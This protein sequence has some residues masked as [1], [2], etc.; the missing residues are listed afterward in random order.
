MTVFIDTCVYLDYLRSAELHVLDV[1][2]E[3]I[4]ARKIKL[5]F[6]DVTR[7]EIW[8]GIPIDYGRYTKNKFKLSMPSVP[9][10]V[11]KGKK[12]EKAKKLLEDYSSAIEEVRKESLLAVKSTMND[13]IEK[14]YSKA[15][16]VREDEK[17]IEAA[18]LRKL[19]CNPPGKKENPLGD[20]IVWELLLQKCS[21]DDLVIIS[22]DGDFSYTDEQETVLHPLLQKEWN[23]RA[24][25][26]KVTVFSSIAT[27]IESIA[28]SKV[29]K[30]DVDSEKKTPKDA[31]ASPYS[32]NVSDTVRV[33]DL[34][35]ISISPNMGAA[36]P[37]TAMLNDP[38]LSTWQPV[39]VSGN[40][41]T[42][43]SCGNCGNAYLT[44]GLTK[45]GTAY[46]C[47]HCS[48]LIY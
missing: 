9:T 23:E 35:G 3:L 45:I 16:K 48:F 19:K 44:E 25:T 41:P 5:I 21:N 4:D 28:P 14:L 30:K 47:P 39:T 37:R 15:E 10:S 40:F 46:S 12:Y 7:S 11:E 6:P 42:I 13:Y 24:P 17:T 29:T 31:F 2:L 26:K 34:S 33:D 27:F 38:S 43:V 8:R 1:L 32:I 18:Q 36:L 22:H 20:E